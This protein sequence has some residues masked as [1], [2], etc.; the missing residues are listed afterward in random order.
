MARIKGS[1]FG[2]VSSR[3]SAKD[4]AADV[5]HYNDD[6]SGLQFRNKR[7]KRVYNRAKNNYSFTKRTQDI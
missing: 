4:T 5:V 1:R 6:D 7:I 3:R 2:T